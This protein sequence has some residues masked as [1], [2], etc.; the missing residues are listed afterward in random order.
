MTQP[1]LL[2]A[3]HI[4]K[5]FGPVRASDDVSLS[6]SEGEIV[7]LLGENG[8]GKSTLVKMMFGTLQPD[9]GAFYWRGKAARL[10]EPADARALG[11]AMVHQHFSLF[12]AFT[13]AQN[14]ALALPDLPM[15][16]IAERTRTV[17]R[18][19]G[20]ALDPDALVA[21]LSVGERQRIEIVRCLLQNPKLIIMDEPTSVLTPQEVERLFAVLRRLASEGC[22]VL[23]ISHKLDE[24]RDLCSRAVVIRA[25]RVVAE[26]DLAAT[27]SAALAEAMVGAAINTVERAAPAQMQTPAL[28]VNALTQ[29]S[30]RPFGTELRDVTF[31][32]HEGEVFGIAGMAGNG[33]AELF[34]CL[35]GENP[36]QRD[37]ISLFGTS[38]GAGGVD[39]RRSLGAAFV[40]EERLGHGA[41]PGFDLVENIILSRH[42]PGD[43]TVGPGGLVRR[44]AA[45]RALD[46]VVSHMDVRGPGAKAPARALSGGNLQKFVMGR[47]LDRAPRLLVVDQPT[48]GVDAGAAA[49]IRQAIIDL[50]AAGAA[51]LVISQDLDELFE[52]AGRIAVISQG[53]LSEARPAGELTRVEV[54]IL[55][56]AGHNEEASVAH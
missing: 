11:I 23:Y 38:V 42:L 20:L 30:N 13:A 3:R 5:S 39:A 24:V 17:S 47:E 48:W 40:P 41:V 37:A 36:S 14:I 44:G 26:A 4:T 25:G 29:A 19:Y 6:V 7:A 54:G 56:G 46:R 21:D 1:A 12:E 43:G 16:E 55:M 22:A 35:S 2:E 15:A 9:D 49:N 31:T 45:R 34:A 52:I 50:A 18:A 10:G 27:T 33:Q 53:R 32:V 8:A 28:V 51:V